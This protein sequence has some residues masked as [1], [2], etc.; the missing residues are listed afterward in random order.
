MKC[1]S[2]RFL[3]GIATLTVVASFLKIFRVLIEIFQFSD[4]VVDN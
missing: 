2:L 3:E 1:V 4:E